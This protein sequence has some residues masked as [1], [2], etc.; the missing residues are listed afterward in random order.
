MLQQIITPSSILHLI[1]WTQGHAEVLFNLIQEKQLEGI[2]IKSI[3]G[4]IYKPGTKSQSWLKVINYNYI[5]V[6]IIGLRKKNFGLLLARIENNDLKYMGIMEF[7]KPE[8]RKEFY[9][10]YSRYIDK[11]DKEITYLK[12]SIKIRVK[13]RNLTSKGKLRIPSFVEFIAYQ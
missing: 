13:Y 6:Y 2:V 12:P 8:A 10:I 3:D 9:K 5:D 1:Q 7:I 11:E 4:S